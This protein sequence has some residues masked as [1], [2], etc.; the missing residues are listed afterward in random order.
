ML[1]RRR[2]GTAR[3]CCRVEGVWSAVEAAI[4]QRDPAA[5][6]PGMGASVAEIRPALGITWADAA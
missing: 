6:G 2:C 4:V 5:G 3:Q 1:V